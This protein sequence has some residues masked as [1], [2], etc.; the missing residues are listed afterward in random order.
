M[1]LLVSF[2]PKDSSAQSHWV[3]ILLG[4]KNLYPIMLVCGNNFSLH[5]PFLSNQAKP[6]KWWW[7]WWGSK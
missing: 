3:N 1:T 7:W 5:T 6:M 4:Q 2:F